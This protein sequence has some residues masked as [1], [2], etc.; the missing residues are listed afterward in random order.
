VEQGAVPDGDVV[1][2]D[3]AEIAREMDDRAVL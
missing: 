1:A 2:H 3:G